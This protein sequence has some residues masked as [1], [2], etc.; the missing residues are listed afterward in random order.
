M[1]RSRCMGYDDYNLHMD[2]VRAIK[3]LCKNIKAGSED[4]LVLKGCCRVVNPNIAEQLY[5]SLTKGLS[6]DEMSKREYIPIYKNDFYGYRRKA[7]AQ[8]FNLCLDTQWR[9]QNVHTKNDV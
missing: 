7:M 9:K 3:E 2:D 4:E 6:Y 8:F 1:M 5:A